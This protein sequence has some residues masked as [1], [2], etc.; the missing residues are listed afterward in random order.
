MIII[1]GTNPSCTNQPKVASG[2]T[3]ALAYY[4]DTAAK[5]CHSFMYSGC[6]KSSYFTTHTACLSTCGKKNIYCKHKV[7]VL[8]ITT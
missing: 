3:S 8:Y 6:D 1:T 2:C 5:Q 7:R 4:Y